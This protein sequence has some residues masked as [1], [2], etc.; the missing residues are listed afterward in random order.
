VTLL[1]LCKE[2]KVPWKESHVMDERVKFIARLLDGEL[3]RNVGPTAARTR[4]PPPIRSEPSSMPSHD[5]IR[6]DDDRSTVGVFSG[7]A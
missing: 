1:A 5:C 6:L 7:F 3:S 2:A 4:F